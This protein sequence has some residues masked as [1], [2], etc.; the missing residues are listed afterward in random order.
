MLRRP[1]ELGLT[2][3][4]KVVLQCP[5]CGAEEFVDEEV[6]QI[7]D[8]ETGQTN[9]LCSRCDRKDIYS[10]MESSDWSA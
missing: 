2:L 9:V 1:A 5:E 10:L 8:E 6:V 7:V 3:S 4:S